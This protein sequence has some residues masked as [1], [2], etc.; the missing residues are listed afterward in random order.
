MLLSIVNNAKD[1]RKLKYSMFVFLKY[2]LFHCFKNTANDQRIKK[3]TQCTT[4][5]SCISCSGKLG[6]QE[7]NSFYPQENFNKCRGWFIDIFTETCPHNQFCI[8]QH[9][10]HCLSNCCHVQ[11]KQL[12]NLDPKCQNNFPVEGK[13]VL[14]EPLSPSTHKAYSFPPS[15]SLLRWHLIREPSLAHV[16]ETASAR[17][18]VPFTRHCFSSWSS[19]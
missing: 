2:N 9:G 1:I 4:N 10:P 17:P 15:G 3:L 6:S 5:Y 7:V 11:H 19:H 12:E 8:T 18:S 16:M 13:R 14:L